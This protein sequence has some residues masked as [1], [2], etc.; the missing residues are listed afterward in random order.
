MRGGKMW[1]CWHI[2]KILLKISLSVLI[3]ATLSFHLNFIHVSVN[4]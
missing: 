1:I 4:L 2:F 3:L